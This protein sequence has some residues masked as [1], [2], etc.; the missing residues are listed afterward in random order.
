MKHRDVVRAFIN[1]AQTARS[2]EELVQLAEAVL[3]PSEVT[4]IL[5]RL[6]ILDQIAEGTPHREIS[7]TLGVGI[8]TVSRGS[9]V[10]QEKNSVLR[11]FFPRQ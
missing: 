3:T 7:D 10:F 8:A 9:R 4:S 11:K 2:E 6:K 1:L 5:Q